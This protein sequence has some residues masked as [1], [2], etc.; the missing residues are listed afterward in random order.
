MTPGVPTTPVDP[1]DHD[2]LATPGDPATGTA[3]HRMATLREPWSAWSKP[4]LTVFAAFASYVI[5]GSALLVTVVLLLALVPGVNVALGVTSGDPT[6]PLDVG[7][8]LAM[9]ALWLPA[10][11]IGVRAGGWRPAGTAFSVAARIRRVLDQPASLAV[12]GGGLLTVLAAG[13]AGSLAPMEAGP[14][15]DDAPSLGALLVLLLVTLVLAPLQVAGLE[16]TMR[17]L[18]M[19]ALGTW[20]RSPLL[21]ILAA[22][23]VML[24]GRELSAAVL[25]PA[26]TLA[27][28][29][30]ALAW[31]SGGLELPVLLTLTV[32]VVGILTSAAAAGTG[33]GSGA[34]AMVAAAAAPGSSSAALAD[35]T[36]A[37]AALTGGI[38]GAIALLVVTAATCVVVSRKHGLPLTQPV[39][40]AADEPLPPVVA[41]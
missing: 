16:L 40:R 34:S 35:G 8:A 7:L 13:V 24:I 14:A 18:V 38:T 9:G 11:L 6:S 27:V 26:L 37:S 19:Q 17:G 41:V 2:E 30:G 23:A 10:G 5:M 20:L 21:P 28:C 1:A 4:L 25:I 15:P 31:K 33:L 12:V 22:A 32:T 39:T 29:A 36:H 3:Y